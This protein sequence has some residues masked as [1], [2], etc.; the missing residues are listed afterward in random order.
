MNRIQ[1]WFEQIAGVCPAERHRWARAQEIF[2][3]QRV[4]ISA[5]QKP[6]CWRRRSRSH[7]AA[8]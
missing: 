3:A 5:L 1:K 2:A 8:R 7:A 6:A 4:D